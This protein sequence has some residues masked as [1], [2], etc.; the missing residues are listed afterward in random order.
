M[1]PGVVRREC[2]EC[3]GQEK[4][5]KWKKWTNYNRIQHDVAVV[6]RKQEKVKISGDCLCVATANN[7][8]GML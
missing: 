1:N 4:K 7:S 8:L 6:V 5:N 2:R 3:V